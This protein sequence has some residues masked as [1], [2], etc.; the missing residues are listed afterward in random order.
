MCSNLDGNSDF[1]LMSFRWLTI[2]I[3]IGQEHMR[4]LC[5]A[6]ETN[7]MHILP[8]GLWSGVET[9]ANKPNTSLRS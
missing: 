2:L 1:P 8:L 6:Y 7:K 9:I 4:T 3:A 5:H